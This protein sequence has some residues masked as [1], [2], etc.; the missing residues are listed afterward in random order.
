VTSKQLLGLFGIYW[1]YFCLT[2]YTVK[3]IKLAQHV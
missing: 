1:A 3:G 2:N